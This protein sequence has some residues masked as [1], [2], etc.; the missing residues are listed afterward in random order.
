LKEYFEGLKPLAPD[1]IFTHW[2]EDDHQDHRLVSELTWNT[3]RNHTV[4][5]YEVPKYDGDLGRPTVF[6]PLPAA[7]RRRKL[8]L[9]MTAFPS[10]RNKQW[11]TPATFEGLMRLRGIECAAPEGYA[12][13]FY[14][15]KL[16][17]RTPRGR[18]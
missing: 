10:Q 6:V 18:R 1:L 11:F 7:L 15:R 2:R 4:L 5:E 3:F 16:L 9:L 8:R 13:A 12:E 17:I 14:A